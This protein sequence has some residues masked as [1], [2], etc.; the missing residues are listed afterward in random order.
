MDSIRV[1]ILLFKKKKKA[2]TGQSAIEEQNINPERKS[3]KNNPQILHAVL[4]KSWKQHPTKLQLL[5]IFKTIEAEQERQVI[6]GE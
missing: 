6:G 1:S 3:D 5:Q 2:P 4:K